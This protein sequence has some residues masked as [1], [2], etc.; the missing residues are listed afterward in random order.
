VAH[1]QIAAFARL[2]KEN[3]PPVRS[4][5][6]QKTLISR[7]I[8]GMSYDALHDEIVTPSPFAQAILTFRGS[9]NGEEAPIRIIQGP[10]TQ[11]LGVTNMVGVDP[12]NNEIIVPTLPGMI[13]VFDREA[14]GDVAPKRVL[15]GPET[16]VRSTR[17]LTAESPGQAHVDAKRNLLMVNSGGKILIFDRLASGDAKPK[18]VIT[19]VNSPSGYNSFQITAK[20]WIVAGCAGGSICAWSLG[21]SG[22][23]TLRSKLP[24]LETTGYQHSGIALDPAHK[25]IILSAAAQRQPNPRPTSGIM[26]AVVTFFWPE[27]F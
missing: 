20:G 27:V 13:L 17:D 15:G 10:H 22:E 11:I 12:D 18:A 5:Q 9:A 26:N 25:E 23:A 8:H 2:A 19:G 3:T 21:E 14:N 16:G 1:P 6:G 7:T 24:F 4:I